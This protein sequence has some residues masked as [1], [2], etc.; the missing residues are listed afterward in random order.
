MMICNILRNFI[1]RSRNFISLLPFNHNNIA[2]ICNTTSHH[3]SPFHC[4]NH[5]FS[6]KS[7]CEFRA[8]HTNT[9]VDVPQVM[10]YSSSPRISSKKICVREIDL[11]EGVLVPA[12]YDRGTISVEEKDV[13][14]WMSCE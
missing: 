2:P 12:N 8:R 3:M 11:G 6:I 5:H 7:S 10:V 13:S 1:C 4:A 9:E 14:L